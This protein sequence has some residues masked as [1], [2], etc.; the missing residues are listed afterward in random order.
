MEVFSGIKGEIGDT[1]SHA[2]LLAVS[3]LQNA[4]PVTRQEKEL[5]A[6][7]LLTLARQG[8]KRPELLS[9][10]AIELLRRRRSRIKAASRQF[11]DPNGTTM[12]PRR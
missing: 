8:V 3:K 5:V 2:Y 6:L 4:G 9:E 12:R 7:R 11:V 1:L 10:A